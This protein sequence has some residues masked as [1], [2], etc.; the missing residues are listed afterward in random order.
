MLVHSRDP[1]ILEAVDHQDA[2]FTSLE[3]ESWISVEGEVP[4]R[5]T[6]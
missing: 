6:P 2:F 5:V 1:K 3:G 4:D